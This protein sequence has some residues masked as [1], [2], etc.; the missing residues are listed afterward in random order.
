MTKRGVLPQLPTARRPRC[1]R[2]QKALDRTVEQL[3][4]LI[5]PPDPPSTA[6]NLTHP[7]Q[8]LT[9]QGKDSFWVT[10]QIA[11]DCV[12]QPQAPQP[13]TGEALGAGA[14]RLH[15]SK[16]HPAMPAR[17]GERQVATVAK[18]DDVLP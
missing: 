7:G 5:Q 17:R 11:R 15:V 8:I 2:L 9:C 16:L 13:V 12:A 10:H 4:P 14:Q 18:V 1:Q 3:L 6:R